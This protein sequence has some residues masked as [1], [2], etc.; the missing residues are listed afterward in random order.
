MTLIEEL[1]LY[2]NFD[3]KDYIDELIEIINEENISTLE[4]LEEYDKESHMVD[5]KPQS[6]EDIIN[7]CIDI[8]DSYPFEYDGLLSRQLEELKNERKLIDEGSLEDR[9]LHTIKYFYL[10]NRDNPFPYHTYNFIIHN[11]L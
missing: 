10:T 6:Y 11:Q 1:K 4:E 7:R 2:E 8:I 9:I 3:N 5:G